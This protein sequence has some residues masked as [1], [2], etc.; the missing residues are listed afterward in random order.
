MSRHRLLAG[1]TMDIPI[2]EVFGE[3]LRSRRI[4]RCGSQIAPVDDRTAEGFQ[5]RPVEH[6]AAGS[7]PLSLTNPRLAPDVASDMPLCALDREIW[8]ELC[9]T[10]PTLFEQLRQY[11]GAEFWVHV[12]QGL[13]ADGRISVP[14]THLTVQGTLKVEPGVARFSVAIPG[15]ENSD[16]AWFARRRGRGRPDYWQ[17][18]IEYRPSGRPALVLYFTAELADLQMRVLR[19]GR[20]HE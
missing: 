10:A 12:E 13:G 17:A 18:A 2:A 14:A 6:V 9:P 11:D 19:S 3:F 1:A 8:E 20:P 5:G 15:W 7:G 16:F 4:I